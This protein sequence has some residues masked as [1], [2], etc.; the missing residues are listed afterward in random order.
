[1]QGS[2]GATY[3]RALQ[4]CHVQR[5]CY[6]LLWTLWLPLP[7]SFQLPTHMQSCR[8]HHCA[9][10]VAYEPEDRPPNPNPNPSPTNVPCYGSSIA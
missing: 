9:P 7:S 1:M 4:G 3:R 5:W 8:R 6:Y 10:Q 2:R